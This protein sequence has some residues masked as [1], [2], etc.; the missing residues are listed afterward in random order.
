[1]DLY[2]HVEAIGLHAAGSRETPKSGVIVGLSGLSCAKQGEDAFHPRV[3]G[4]GGVAK[5]LL[6]LRIHTEAGEG[7]LLQLSGFLA[8]F[9]PGIPVLLI[10][11]SD[12]I[13][14]N[15]D[16]DASIAG[17]GAAAVPA[18]AHGDRDDAKN[19]QNRENDPRSAIHVTSSHHAFRG[20]SWWVVYS[21]QDIP[22]RTTI[23]KQQERIMR[24]YRAASNHNFRS[25][26]STYVFGQGGPI[27]ECT[28]LRIGHTGPEKL[29][30][31]FYDFWTL[32]WKRI[33]RIP[34]VQ[35]RNPGKGSFGVKGGCGVKG[36]LGIK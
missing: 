29:G 12:V 32:I 34:D 24:Y 21:T 5:G 35:R 15:T 18:S 19:G 1:V 28:A 6:L 2:F 33:G 7:E 22:R 26:I 14:W 23:H 10:A 20:R 17:F 13:T 31:F 25:K 30:K 11:F 4:V 16:G 8:P 36:R 9:D 3:H 27:P